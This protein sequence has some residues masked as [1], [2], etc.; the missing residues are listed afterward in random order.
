MKQIQSYLN[1]CFEEHLTEN[2]KPPKTDPHLQK[3]I[4]T[5][6]AVASLAVPIPGLTLAISQ[7]SDVNIYKC[8]IRCEQAEHIKNKNLCYARCKY[9]A[10]KWSVNYLERELNKCNRTKKP[11]KCRKKLFK[12]LM[13]YKKK[14][15]KEE[16]MYRYKERKARAEG[17]I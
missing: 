14:L 5:G 16:I 9:E 17:K 2:L 7:I 13:T 1:L 3:T 8:R 12:M 11:S 15:A 4:T 6:L 10:T